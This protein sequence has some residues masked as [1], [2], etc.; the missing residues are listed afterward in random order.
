MAGRGILLF[1]FAL[2]LLAIGFPSTPWSRT[3]M[4]GGLQAVAVL[5]GLLLLAV[6]ALEITAHRKRER[7]AQSGPWL[8]GDLVIEGDVP[9][10]F[11]GC[12]TRFEADGRCWRMRCFTSDFPGGNPRLGQRHPAR[13]CLDEDGAIALLDLGE[14][15]IVPAAGGEEVERETGPDAQKV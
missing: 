11:P 7:A 5:G 2:P 12:E 14:C 13:A 4:D 3:D 1:L 9:G 15:D 10:R 6:G 8:M